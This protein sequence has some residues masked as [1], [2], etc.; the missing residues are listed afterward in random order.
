[1]F[2]HMMPLVSFDNL[3]FVGTCVLLCFVFV[4]DWSPTMMCCCILLAF[5]FRMIS[6]LP[7]MA[8]GWWWMTFSVTVRMCLLPW[9]CRQHTSVVIVE[10]E[11][12]E[13]RRSSIYTS[14]ILLRFVFTSLIIVQSLSTCIYV[15]D[16]IMPSHSSVH[17]KHSIHRKVLVFNLKFKFLYIWFQHVAVRLWN[18]WY[19]TSLAC[20]GVSLAAARCNN[21]KH[22]FHYIHAS[23]LAPWLPPKLTP[24]WPLNCKVNAQCRHVR[25]PPKHTPTVVWGTVLA[26]VPRQRKYMTRTCS[27]TL[28]LAARSFKISSTDIYLWQAFACCPRDA[29]KLR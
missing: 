8:T 28:R 16:N 4:L 12:L 5:W 13:P 6:R 17:E 20:R 9:P 10:P 23:H 27:R 1:M 18:D 7:C 29:N 22:P 14:L 19:V 21:C 25:I 15:I 24:K 2:T 3:S 11:R 26:C